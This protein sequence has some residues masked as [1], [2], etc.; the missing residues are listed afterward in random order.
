MNEI[1]R[2]IFLVGDR[3]RL[4]QTVVDKSRDQADK[5]EITQKKTAK[6]TLL[7]D[8]KNRLEFLRTFQ[9]TMDRSIKFP[10]SQSY[11]NSMVLGNSPG[12]SPTNMMKANANKAYREETTMSRTN[13]N[14]AETSR[15][16]H[17]FQGAAGLGEPSL[18]CSQLSDLAIL[19]KSGPVSRRTGMFFKEI[20]ESPLD[21]IGIRKIQRA[22]ISAQPSPKNKKPECNQEKY[23]KEFVIRKKAFEKKI[24]GCDYNPK[25]ASGS[26]IPG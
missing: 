13:G 3:F 5:A 25:L 1:E 6:E 14:V 19:E 7:H 17:S 8:L 11:Q 12:G 24:K 21:A 20:N 9:P 4:Y 18:M 26:C 16:P 23:S 15:I 22:T 2:I 10:M